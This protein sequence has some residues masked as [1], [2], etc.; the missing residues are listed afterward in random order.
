MNTNR[1]PSKSRAE[2]CSLARKRSGIFDPQDIPLRDFGHLDKKNRDR[3]L[4]RVMTLCMK[5]DE[6]AV[7]SIGTF[8]GYCRSLPFGPDRIE[9]LGP[10]W[11]M[12]QQEAGYSEQRFAKDLHGDA[13]RRYRRTVMVCN[14][15]E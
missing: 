3:Q 11:I 7:R 15:K 1:S 9:V 14:H 2:G 4:E 12:P 5:I 10:T 13:R 6:Q 8:F